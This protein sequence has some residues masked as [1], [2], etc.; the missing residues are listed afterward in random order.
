MKM[1]LRSGHITTK[2]S[3]RIDG[4]QPDGL[5]LTAWKKGRSLVWDYTCTDTMVL[6][7]IAKNS[8]EAA[9]SSA[10][11]EKKKYHTMRSFLTN[12]LSCQ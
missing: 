10:Q 1:A 12:T 9:S 2:N 3:S 8:H 7:N 5:T 11:A 4:K 6:S